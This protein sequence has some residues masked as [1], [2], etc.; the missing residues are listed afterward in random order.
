MGNWLP[1]P[2][3]Q[4]CIYTAAEA[5]DH[6]WITL[7][8]KSVVEIESINLQ[9]INL[10]VCFF[11]TNS[12]SKKSSAPAPSFGHQHMAE[13]TSKNRSKHSIELHYHST[14]TSVPCLRLCCRFTLSTQ[15]SKFLQLVDRKCCGWF[16]EFTSSA[17]LQ[18]CYW[19]YLLVN[20]PFDF[21]THV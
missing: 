11:F 16:I 13:F 10:E 15:I 3:K 2:E 7:T 6:A 12:P 18:P 5:W 4:N 20:L 19:L 9:E 8:T 21:V 14:F 1:A 17:S